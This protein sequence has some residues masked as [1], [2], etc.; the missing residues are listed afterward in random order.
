MAAGE[1]YA[2]VVDLERADGSVFPCALSGRQVNPDVP[3]EGFILILQ[4]ITERRRMEDELRWLA[5]TDALTGLPN[6]RHF[7]DLAQSERQRAVRHGHELS[8]LMV[9]VDYFKSIND[10]YGHGVGDEVLRALAG[11]IS[12][13]LREEELVGRL[14]GE[15]FAVLLP[16][17]GLEGALDA[18]GRLREQVS[19]AP[20][21]TGQGDLNVTVSIGVSDW[22]EA[23]EPVESLLIRADEALY[24]AKNE[25]RDRVERG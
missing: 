13:S 10:T 4:D 25:G 1:T 3:A 2:E 5:T 9:D 22:R 7:L 14:G 19:R 18:A 8:L 15:E 23:E 17:T 16:E 11:M 21:A 6:R 20:V 24:A 12:D